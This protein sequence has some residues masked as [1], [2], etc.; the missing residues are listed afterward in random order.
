MAKYYYS[1]LKDNKLLVKGEIEALNPREAREK[2][3]QLGFL[4]TKIYM[5][6]QEIPSQIPSESA[7]YGISD[8]SVTG[9]SLNDKINF[10]SQLQV[11]LSSGISILD[12]L[13]AIEQNSP[14]IKLCKIAAR[15]RKDITSGMT[16]TQALQKNYSQ[17]FGAVYVGLCVSGEAS[18]ELDVTLDRMLTLLRKEQGIKDK[19]VRASIY[20]A[21]LILI[22]FGVLLLFAKVVFPAFAGV[23][24]FNGGNI[25][26][27]AALLMGIC[28]FVSNF[29]YL[30]ILAGIGGVFGVI[31]LMKNPQFRQKVD[32]FIME[33][34]VLSEFVRYINLSNFMSVLQ[35]SYD[36]GVTILEGLGLAKQTVKNTIVLSQVNSALNLVKQGKNLSESFGVTDLLPNELLMMV[37]TGEKSGTLGKMLADAV[38]VIDR[39]VEM[40]LETLTRLFEPACI[41]ILGGFVLF[42]A[43]AFYQLYTGMLGSLF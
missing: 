22:M 31:N 28:N 36:A 26:L 27:L 10:T 25:P 23:I 39:K 40:V 14:R 1:A 4:P 29:W 33:I 11:M 16:F 37:A 19:V 41:V 43:L 34:P 2:I 18:G 30:I 15:L 38:N 9:L 35:V 42:I 8:T 3:R 12:A 21:V 20:P 6:E 13:Q 7:S 32:K 5:E 17:V 24:T